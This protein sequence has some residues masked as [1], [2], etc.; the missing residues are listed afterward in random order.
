MFK[1][2]KGACIASRVLQFAH[3]SSYSHYSPPIQIKPI[4][5]TPVALVGCVCEVHGEYS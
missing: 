1:E 2:K 5:P 3:T 4:K